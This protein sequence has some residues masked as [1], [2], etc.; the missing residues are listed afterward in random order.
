MRCLMPKPQRLNRES[1]PSPIDRVRKVFTDNLHF[2][3]QDADVIDLVLA[4]VATSGIEGDPLWMHYVDVPSSGKTE[5]LRATECERTYFLSDLTEHSFISGYV[6]PS[7]DGEE[8]TDF[9]LLPK[10]DGKTLVVLDFTTILPSSSEK[11]AKIMGDLRAIFDGYFSR[12][13]G[14]LGKR[15]YRSRFNFIT[16]VTPDI[17]KAWSLNTLGERFLMWRTRGRGDQSRRR[18]AR[19]ALEGANRIDEIREELRTA[20]TEFLAGLPEKV[21]FPILPATIR[22][23]IIDLAEVLA[24]CRTFIHR[25]KDSLLFPPQPEMP[26]RIAKQLLRIGQSVAYVR[27]KPEV[28]TDEVAIM[29]KVVMDSLPTNR[30]ITLEALWQ[31][32]AAYCEIDTIMEASGLP[33]TTQRRVLDD[34]ARLKIVNRKKLEGHTKKPFGYRLK[35]LFRE[36]LDKVGGP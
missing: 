11:R 32:R 15:E 20:V 34:F 29:R 24:T 3:Q 23:R 12:Q 30:R 36:Y 7:E 4:I 28:T 35:Q 26:A 27:G 19:Q 1:P 16:A 13:L 33:L 22:E 2:D 31:H 8:K 10:L 5:L 21:M 18:Q 17:E 9:S 14:N 6:D 25:D